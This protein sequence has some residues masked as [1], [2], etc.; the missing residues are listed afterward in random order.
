[1]N[2]SLDFTQKNKNRD[3]VNYSLTAQD[4]INTFPDYL[5]LNDSTRVLYKCTTSGGETAVSIWLTFC[6]PF[7]EITPVLGTY[8]FFPIGLLNSGLELDIYTNPNTAGDY[9]AFA[10]YQIRLAI[11]TNPLLIQE[12]RGKQINGTFNDY[13]RYQMAGSTRAA[14]QHYEVE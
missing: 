14:A 3:V 6:V 4:Y 10:D 8:P 5:L 11:M 13:F 12:L 9:T 2:G 7:P 1:M